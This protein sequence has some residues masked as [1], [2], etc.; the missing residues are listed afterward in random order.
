MSIHRHIA[1]DGTVSY[2]L[3]LRVVGADGT[4]HHAQRTIH[5]TKREAQDALA[6]WKVEIER[7]LAVDRSTMTV[8]ALLA[9]WLDTYIK[10]RV[11]ITT[12]DSYAN[13]VRLHLTPGLGGVLVQSLTPLRIQ[14][15]YRSLE[16]QGASDVI[17]RRCA[18][19]LG[20]AL[21][22]AVSPLGILPQN[23][24]QLARLPER[25]AKPGTKRPKIALTREQ[26][27]SFLEA[28]QQ[29]A[30]GPLYALLLTTG[31]RRGEALGL[32]WRDIDWTGEALQVVQNNTPRGG[33][34]FTLKDPK[35]PSAARTVRVP[36]PTLEALRSWRVRQ[37]ETRLAAG[38]DWQEEY[39]L[40]FCDGDGT[41]IDPDRPWHD[42]RKVRAMATGVPQELTIH[43]LRHTFIT[44]ALQNGIPME[45]VSKMA[46]HSR[47]SITMDVYSHVHDS[48]ERAA[49]AVLTD[50]FYPRAQDAQSAQQAAE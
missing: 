46:G 14:Q 25:K 45:V 27:H 8:G 30:W 11:A 1:K 38:A 7:G 19:H 3:R 41:P 10:D 43:H 5:G 44:L 36:P 18:L 34:G 15:F 2:H 16:Q 13:V 12:Y 23:P 17:V 47:V 22:V 26:A 49:V 20:R 6:R 29:S 9:Y 28:A 35:S 24:A 32:R 40:V 31:I 4:V 42:F 48:V 21:D 33:P 39:D 37:H 50:V